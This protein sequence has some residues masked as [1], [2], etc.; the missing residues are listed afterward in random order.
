MTN[1]DRHQLADRWHSGQPTG[2]VMTYKLDPG[3]IVVA[4]RRPFRIDR[5][6]ELPTDKWPDKFVEV[7]RD[8]G[9]PDPHTWRTRP[10]RVNG[11][12]EGPGADTRN[13]GT[14]SPANHSWSTL[15]EHYAV[16][17]K[18]L[19]LPPCR[20]VHNERVMQRAT[21]RMAEDMAILPGSCHGCREPITKR[22]KSFT[23]PGANLVRPDLGDNSA[24]FHTRGRCFSAVDAYDKRWAKAEEGRER[25]FF[26]GGTMTI[27]YDDTAECDNPRCVAKGAHRDLVDHQCRVWHRPGPGSLAPGCWCVYGAEQEK[28]A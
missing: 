23:F 9:M 16:C 27:H 18:C 21:E 6:T 28:A 19:E 15:P 20:H 4:K 8:Q 17:H 25:L 3:Q 24:I 14:I 13:H 22:Q 12:W 10:M 11:Y 26:C 5:V 2:W 1:T 7:W